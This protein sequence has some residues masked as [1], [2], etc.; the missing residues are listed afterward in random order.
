MIIEEKLDFSNFET[1]GDNFLEKNNF[2]Y[3]L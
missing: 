2:K 3:V 1:S